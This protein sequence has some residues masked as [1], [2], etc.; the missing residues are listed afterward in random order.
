MEKKHY[1]KCSICVPA[2][3]RMRLLNLLYYRDV[4]ETHRSALHLSPLAPSTL[5]LVTRRQRHPSDSLTSA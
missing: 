5:A 3:R 2:I 1:A 4:K